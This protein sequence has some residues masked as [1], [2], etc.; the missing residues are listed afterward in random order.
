MVLAKFAVIAL[1]SLLISLVLLA[2]SLAMGMLIGLPGWSEGVVYAG[3]YAYVATVL[4]TILLCTPVAFFA[5]Y[6]RGYLPPVGFVIAALIVAQFVVA[7]NLGPY[8]PWAI[9]ALYGMAMT[10]GTLMPGMVSYV[11]LALMSLAGLIATLAWWRY[12]DQF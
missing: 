7:L 2:A 4:M 6:G 11:I 8:F 12:A 10:S 9:P 1:W 3:I 5:C